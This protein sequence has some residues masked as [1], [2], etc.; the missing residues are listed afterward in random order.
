MISEY[1]GVILGD[2]QLEP[3]NYA[4]R[5]GSYYGSG[6]PLRDEFYNYEGQVCRF[7]SG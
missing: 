6:G 3:Q 2:E 4:R 1:A 5:A 7:V